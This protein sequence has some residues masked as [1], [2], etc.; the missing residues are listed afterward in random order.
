[1]LLM[2]VEALR[3]SRVSRALPDS[4]LWE[5]FAYPAMFAKA[6]EPRFGGVENG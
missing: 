2:M 1:M 4:R 3:L 6:H 5:V